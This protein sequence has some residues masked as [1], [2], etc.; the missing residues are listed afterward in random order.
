MAP[1]T[2]QL[3]KRQSQVD[4]SRQK[5]IAAAR[6]L[7]GDA[8]GYSSFTVN[9]VAARADVARATVYYQFVSKVGLLEAVC[10][11]L[12]K[13]GQMFELPSA[14][15]NPD[16][17]QAIETFIT[18]F[19]RFWDADRQVM[20]RLR[21]LAALDPEVGAVISGRDERRRAGLEVLM[22]RL[23]AAGLLT[24][25]KDL[26]VK[27]LVT[28]TSFET[29]DTLAAPNQALTEVAPIVSSMAA[30]VWT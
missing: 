26:A 10:D 7:L 27:I 12:A 20:R 16:P 6:S 8:S 17:V 29:F 9:A 4:E 3:G 1:R 22:T 18:S 5:V 2:Y 13:D 24:V 19:G 21:G 14:F 15:M 23:D 25:A 28:L 11:A 30:R